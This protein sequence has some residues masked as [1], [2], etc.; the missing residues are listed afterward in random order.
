MKT[1]C[2]R[3]GLKVRKEVLGEDYVN[4]SI[5]GADEF[6]R[7]MAEWST[8]FCWGALLDPARR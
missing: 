3:S 8:E 2:L 1:A 7:T 4:K 5:A 6:T